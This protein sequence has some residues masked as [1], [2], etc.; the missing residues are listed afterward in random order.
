MTLTLSASILFATGCGERDQE[1]SLSSNPPIKPSIHE[2]VVVI[3]TISDSS[4]FTNQSESQ[5][6]SNNNTQTTY[7]QPTDDGIYFVKTW[8][9]NQRDR[10]RGVT[11]DP[12]G[13]NGPSIHAPVP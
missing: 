1:N 13:G 3:D 4:E 9:G 8:G 7:S 2:T 11:L 10:G 5:E 6:T 12:N